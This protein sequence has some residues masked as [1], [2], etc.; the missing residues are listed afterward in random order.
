[1]SLSP[2][3]VLIYAITAPSLLSFQPNRYTQ[4]TFKRKLW[5]Y[6]KGDYPKYRQKI[7]ETDWAQI[8]IPTRPIDQTV[9]MFNTK[10]LDIASTCIPNKVINVKQGLIPWITSEIKRTMRKRDR[11]R[12]KAKKDN[13]IYSWS[14]FKIIRNKVVYL[15][16][17]AKRNYHESLCTKIKDNKF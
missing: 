12:R 9:P 2:F 5:L 13:S 14:K 17:C 6:E 15:L 16:R 3:L 4:N 7:S 1:M 11:L 8:I 10:L